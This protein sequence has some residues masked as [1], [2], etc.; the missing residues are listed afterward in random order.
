MSNPF[1]I[2]TTPVQYLLVWKDPTGQDRAFIIPS[3]NA[4]VGSQAPATS[5]RFPVDLEADAYIEGGPI[6]HEVITLSGYSGREDRESSSRHGAA[7]VIR[8]GPEAFEELRGFLEDYAKALSQVAGAVRRVS[9]AKRHPQLL[10]YATWEKLAWVIGK[11]KLD[12]RHTNADGT[13]AYLWTLQFETVKRLDDAA[14]PTSP[15]LAEE[16][17]VSTIIGD[18]ITKNGFDNPELVA[19]PRF[20]WERAKEAADEIREGKAPSVAV[21]D[22]LS[23]IPGEPLEVAVD[24]ALVVVSTEE[25]EV[26]GADLRKYIDDCK[27]AL[28]RVSAVRRAAKRTV[29]WPGA[30]FSDACDVVTTTLQEIDATLFDLEDPRGTIQRTLHKIEASFLRVKRGLEKTFAR[31]GKV[32]TAGQRTGPGGP[33]TTDRVAANRGEQCV[34]REVNAGETLP[35]FALRVLG[36]RD[37]WR[38]IARVNGITDPWHFNSGVPLGTGGFPLLVPVPSGASLPRDGSQDIFGSCWRVD[39]H[40]QLIW[41]SSAFEKVRGPSAWV[42][43]LSMRFRHTLG[44]LASAPECGVEDIIGENSASVDIAR[45]TMRVREQAL[46]DSR[47]VATERLRVVRDGDAVFIEADVRSVDG[48]RRELSVPVVVQGRP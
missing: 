1:D 10:L 12:W 7:S 8:S 41:R 40:G 25:V 22:V 43:A 6:K 47:T 15:L 42:Q 46:R 21:P 26:L 44:S 34:V 28:A 37:L 9:D 16:P 27:R 20:S 33:T 3:V 30:V 31:A 36:A 32:R 38:L 14:P 48:K 23:E 11:H 35:E 2:E 5:V 24:N 39:E 29:E 13:L 19:T 45:F 4:I 18:W 17:E